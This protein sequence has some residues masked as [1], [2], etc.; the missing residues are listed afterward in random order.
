[1]ADMQ[2]ADQVRAIVDPVDDPVD[3][4]ASAIQYSV[5]PQAAPMLLKISSKSARARGSNSTRYAIFG[6]K[7]VENFLRRSAQ[8]L[9]Q[10]FEPLPNTLFSACR[11]GKITKPLIRLRV[12]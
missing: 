2:D 8:P 5:Q 3:A 1:M 9:L 10:L 12:L 11:R 4:T 7:F 6:A